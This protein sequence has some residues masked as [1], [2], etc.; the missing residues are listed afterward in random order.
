M[1]LREILL[2]KGLDFPELILEN[3]AG[4]SRNERISASSMGRLLLA[5][6]RSPH[7]SEFESSLPVAALDG[8][9]KGRLNGNGVAGHAHLKTGSLKEVKTLAG[10]VVDKAGRRWA[11]VFF[12]NHVNAERGA[13]AQDAL[14]E[15]V[16]QG[17]SP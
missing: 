11:V 13:T 10:Y 15:W 6:S 1:A 12:I 16:Y 8:T 14:I 4:L 7:F 9:M 3:G 17:A 5:A 2:A